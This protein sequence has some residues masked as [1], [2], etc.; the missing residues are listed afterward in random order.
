MLL[1]AHEHEHTPSAER[2]RDALEKSRCAERA[3]GDDDYPRA[4]PAIDLFCEG[5]DDVGAGRDPLESWE[6]ELERAHTAGIIAARMGSA[7]CRT[8]F[9]EQ[10]VG[11][12][13]LA[14]VCFLNS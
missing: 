9:A 4:T 12:Q 6:L 5:V 8:Y 13:P 2:I 10:A 3:A 7:K 1:R 14:S 11:F